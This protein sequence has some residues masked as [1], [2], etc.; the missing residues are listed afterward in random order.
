[1]AYITFQPKDH[2][3]T[4]AWT[5]TASSPT[6]VTGYGFNPDMIWNKYRAGAGDHQLYDAVRTCLLYTSPSPRDS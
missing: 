5:G 6:N 1:M 3:N 4:V 2:M